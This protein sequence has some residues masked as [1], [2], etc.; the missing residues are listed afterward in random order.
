M[1][2]SIEIPHLAAGQKIAEFKKIY[3][4]SAA[5]LTVPQQLA[6]LPIYVHR[7]DGEKQL[8]FTASSKKDIDEAFTFL[9]EI[10]DGKPC[11]ITECQK[12]FKLAPKNLEIDGIRSFF[13][14]LWDIAERAKISSDVCIKRFL[15]V[16]PGG[17]K[18]FGE[19]EETI[20]NDMTSTGMAEWFRDTLE[21][22]EKKLGPGKK[23]DITIKEEQFVFTA[24]NNENIPGWAREM[25]K[26]IEEIQLYIDQENPPNIANEETS[27]VF[28]FEKRNTRSNKGKLKTIRCGTCSKSGHSDKF[29]F[30][31]ICENC[32]GKGHDADGCTSVWFKNKKQKKSIGQNLS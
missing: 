29:C 12:F 22:I 14:E 30:H 19:R 21:K 7:T 16:I 18:L 8:A 20:K 25:K 6:C 28:A 17:K 2:S 9:E 1:I 32:G 26:N 11:V 15:S 27:D 3:V 13:F 5:A 4:A 23:T 10:I 24:E 31:R